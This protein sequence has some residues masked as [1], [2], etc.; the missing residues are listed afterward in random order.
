MLEPEKTVFY[1]NSPREK[2][3][4]IPQRDFIPYDSK[5]VEKYDHMPEATEAYY[6]ETFE[7]GGNPLA[8]HLIP[9]VLYKGSIE[10][11]DLAICTTSNPD[12]SE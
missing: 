7:A 9:H 1:L 8:H 2:G 11:K 4:A 10:T 3:T 6:K 12:K 5:E